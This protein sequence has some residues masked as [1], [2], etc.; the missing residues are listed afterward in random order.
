M[1]VSGMVLL[2]RRKKYGKKDSGNPAREAGT[3]KA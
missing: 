1:Q 2:E 3:G